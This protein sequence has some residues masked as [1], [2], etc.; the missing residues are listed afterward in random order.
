MIGHNVLGL[1]ARPLLARPIPSQHF[2]LTATTAE[3]GATVTIHRMTP[4]AGKSLEIAWGDGSTTIVA[5][6]DTTVK[7]HVYAAA[8][9]W[10][11]H[12]T[13]ARD[14]VGIDLHD[15]Q[16]SGVKSRELLE[17]AVIYFVC[18]SLG[19]AVASVIDSADMVGWTPTY[20]H[21][22]SMPAASTTWTIAA[23][24]FAGFTTCTSF[25]ANDNALTQAQINA[26][27]WGLYQASVAPRTIA[28]G[29]INVGTNAAPSGVYQA[30]AACPV[31]VA[32]PGKEVAHELSNDGCAVG[33]NRWTAVTF[34]V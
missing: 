7:S 30:A 18:Y 5:A 3:P 16:L 9:T 27:L 32:T 21:L 1:P 33:F 24:N 15:A 6:G 10:A 25:L 22:Y 28:G 4:A 29:T 20:W 8:G 13:D 26:L 31:S 2:T 11:V 19:A 34:T 12:A 23:N 17:S 14:I